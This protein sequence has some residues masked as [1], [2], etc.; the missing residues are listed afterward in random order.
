[1]A[2]HPAD[3]RL[4]T[5]EMLHHY[6]YTLVFLYAVAFLLRVAAGL[7]VSPVN[8]RSPLENDEPEYYQIARSILDRGEYAMIVQQ[9]LDRTPTP[10]AFRLPIPSLAFAVGLTAWGDSIAAL[11]MVSVIVSAFSAPLLFLFALKIT[12][13][14]GAWI[15]ALVGAAWPPWLV[16]SIAVLS[17]PF[18]VPAL[19]LGL[20]LSADAL[21]DPNKRRLFQAG[22]SWGLASMIRPHGLPMMLLLAAMFAAR[23]RLRGA[24]LVV[25]GFVIMVLPWTARN[26]ITM[27]HPTFMETVGGETFFGS[28]NQEVLETPEM[29]GMWIAPL[30]VPK[31]KNHLKDIHNEHERNREQYNMAFE[32]LGSHLADIPRLIVYKVVRWLTPLT[33]SKGIIRLAVFLTYVPLALLVLFGFIGRRYPLDPPRILA[34]LWSFTLLVLCVVMWGILTRGRLLL[35]VIWIPWAVDT[36]LGLLRL[37]GSSEVEPEDSR[38]LAEPATAR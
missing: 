22:L 31:Y 25:L 29:H 19:L 26:Q 34:L 13:R 37:Q 14:R 28:N 33:D 38:V 24:M 18:F 16:Y 21:A 8:F 27:G 5:W 4:T 9:S 30:L 1:M 3:S 35:E 15:S 11:R 6:R 10:T 7:T 12:T 17:E 2:D 32:F 23:G 36:A 20:I